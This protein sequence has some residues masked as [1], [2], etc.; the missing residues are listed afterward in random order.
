[1]LHRNQATTIR[2]CYA[3]GFV[4]V[5]KSSP[6]DGMVEEVDQERPQRTRKNRRMSGWLWPI[7]LAATSLAGVAVLAFRG[8]WHRRM[9]WPVRMENCSYQVCLGCGVKR[10]FDEKRFCAYGPFRYDLNQLIAWERSNRAEPTPA[11]KI[12]RPAS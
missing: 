12:E 2:V 6:G 7:G 3:R 4:L 9:S 5:F 10:L 8:C 1:M 11:P